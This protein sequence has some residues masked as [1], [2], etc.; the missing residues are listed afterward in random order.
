VFEILLERNAEKI[1]V[2]SPNQFTIELF[3]R[4]TR[5]RGIPD[6]QDAGNLAGAKTI[7]GYASV[8]IV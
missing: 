3:R 4:L 6:R 8:T 2:G 7:G 5:F 1:C